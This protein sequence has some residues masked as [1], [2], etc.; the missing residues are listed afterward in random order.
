[1]AATT[2]IAA[3]VARIL[4]LA[5][6]CQR[7]LVATSPKEDQQA[8]LADAMGKPAPRRLAVAASER[9]RGDVHCAAWPTDP[10]KT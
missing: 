4:A 8:W 1:M 6:Q 3:A 5:E 2:A 7:E 9:K 10:Q